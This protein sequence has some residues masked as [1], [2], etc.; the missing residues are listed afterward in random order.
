M[1]DPDLDQ[2]L[3]NLINDLDQFSRDKVFPSGLNIFEA[4]GLYRQE[5]RHSTFLAFLLNPQE[6][7]GLGDA[8]LKRII[9]KALDN[10][11]TELPII[12]H[13]INLIRR[14]IVPD[15]ELIEQCRK[16]YARHKDALDLIIRYGDVNAFASAADLFFKNH[17]DL[18]PLLVRSGQAAFLPSSLFEIVPQIDG[19]NWWG[20]SRPIVF[21][22][23]HYP[24]NR[25]GLILE[26]GPIVGKQFNRDFLVTE[27]LEYFENKKRITPK[28]TRVCSEYRKLTEDQM[29]DPEEILAIMNSLYENIV[30]KHL[31]SV[32]KISR[33]FFQK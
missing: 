28:Y 33:R 17:S 20:Q 4:A 8:F 15:Q 9:Q 25:L 16:L 14:N 22:F 29:G 10:L 24:K 13:Y 31:S 30:G 6:D 27:L 11:S 21:W 3:I 7:H 5:I 12:D 32:I 1:Q 2:K 26:V 18:K 23:Y 19:V